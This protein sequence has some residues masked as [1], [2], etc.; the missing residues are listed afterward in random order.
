ME[1]TINS[2]ST[3][4]F[5]NLGLPFYFLRPSEDEYAGLETNGSQLAPD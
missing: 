4:G 5:L 3:L 1:E 2:V